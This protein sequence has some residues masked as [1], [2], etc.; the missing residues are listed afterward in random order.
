VLITPS[1]LQSGDGHFSDFRFRPG[2]ISGCKAS[3]GTKAKSDR[4]LKTRPTER[5]QSG[6][7]CST[8]NSPPPPG[9]ALIL[10]KNRNSTGSCRLQFGHPGPNELWSQPQARQFDRQQ[11]SLLLRDHERA[12]ITGLAVEPSDWRH[13]TRSSQGYRDG[14]VPLR[15]LHE[16]IRQRIMIRF[17]MHLLVTA[18]LHVV[19]ECP[20]PRA[21]DSGVFPGVGIGTDVVQA[22]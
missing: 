22:D 2:I 10:K 6:R 13:L 20:V 11:A 15:T 19:M 16:W 14:Y 18:A 1:R 8:G 7:L 4:A 5:W 9:N 3:G 17:S 12:G 21:F